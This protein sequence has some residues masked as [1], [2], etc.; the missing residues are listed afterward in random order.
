V[1]SERRRSSECAAT[2]EMRRFRPFAVPGWNRDARRSRDICAAHGIVEVRR[3][4]H[5]HQTADVP[6][7]GSRQLIEQPLRFF[8][9]GGVE[10]LGKPA[11]DGRKQLTPFASPALLAPQPSEAYGGTQFI[12]PSA[13][14]AGNRQGGV[15]RGFG[16]CRIGPRQLAHQLAAQ[17]VQLCVRASLAGNG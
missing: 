1:G 10:T 16:L 15:E 5:P 17:A 2:G 12:P 11:V 4:G 9:V 14:L 6:T 8:Q 3:S 7:A 13:L